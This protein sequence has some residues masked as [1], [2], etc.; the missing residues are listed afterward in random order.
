MIITMTKHDLQQELKEKVKAGVKP[1]H[2]KK[3]KRSKSVDDIVSSSVVT[4]LQKSKSQLE[5]P[6]TQP[7]P[8][9]QIT[10]LQ[11][12]VKFHAQTAQNYLQSLQTAQA[13]ITELE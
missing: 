1:S 11:E 6:I 4:P 2:L 7:S 10:D 5:I 3:L 9:Q 12:Q 13:K 8:N